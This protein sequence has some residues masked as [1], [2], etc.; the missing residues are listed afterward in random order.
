MAIIQR[1][2]PGHFCSADKCEYFEHTDIST[3]DHEEDTIYCVSSVGAMPAIEPYS[4]YTSLMIGGRVYEKINISTI[5]EI[6]LSTR[7]P[8]TPGEK[9][10]ALDRTTWQKSNESIKDS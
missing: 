2:V 10:K 4:L 3:S 1:D 5:Y 8:P 9:L 6:M 7:N